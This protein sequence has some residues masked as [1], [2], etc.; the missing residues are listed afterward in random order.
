[1]LLFSTIDQTPNTTNIYDIS[2]VP[3]R[4]KAKCVYITYGNII[5]PR[6]YYFVSGSSICHESQAVCKIYDTERIHHII[7]Y[8]KVEIYILLLWIYVIIER[9]AY[10]LVTDIVVVITHGRNC[11][12]NDL[13]LQCCMYFQ[14]MF[15]NTALTCI[16]QCL[17]NTLDIN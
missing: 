2:L 17:R 12:Y 15:N 4:L 14:W 3:D 16:K 6:H 10:Q 7:V 13:F 11:L 1:M 9:Q 8:R 5:N